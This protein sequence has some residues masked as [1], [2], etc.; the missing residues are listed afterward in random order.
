MD[1]LTKLK[2][3]LGIAAD[4]TSQD[5]ELQLLLDDVEMDLLTWT[6]RT[7]IPLGL[8]SI[9]RQIAVMRYN[10]QGAEG[11]TARSEGGISRSF[12]DLPGSIQSGISQFRKLKVATYATD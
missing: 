3:M 4:D 9:Q 8:E 5:A 10:K 7:A 11:E 2:I 6:N 1:T 12:E